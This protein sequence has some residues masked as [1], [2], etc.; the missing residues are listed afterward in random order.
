MNR[1]TLLTFML[2][3]VFVAEPALCQESS[4]DAPVYKALAC[5]RPT[6]QSTWAILERDG[7]SRQV[8]R[9]LSSL[10]QG[11]GGIGVISSPPFSIAGDTITFTI[12]GHDGQGGGRNENYIAL[13]DARKGTVLHKT[14][15]PG[16][17][18]LQESSWDVRDIKGVEVR[19]E[20]HDGNR[21]GAFAWLGIGRIDASPSLQ[22]DFSQ[23]MPAGWNRSQQESAVRYELITDGI[24]FRRDASIYSIIPEQGDVE[25]PCGFP[26]RRIYLL[27]CT[28]SVGRPLAVYG[29]LELHYQ[30]GSVD[31]MPLMYGFTLDGQDKLLSPSPTIHLHPSG[32]PFQYYLPIELRD[33]PLDKI[34]LV[35]NP[36]RGPIPR[37]TA[38]T[39]ETMAHSDH[40]SALPETKLA[41]EEQSWIRTHTVSAASPSRDEIASDIRAA[42]RLEKPPTSKVHFQ[43]VTIDTAFRSEGVAVADFNGDG[44]LDIATGNQYY[45][46]PDWKLQPMF[47][48]PVAFPLVGY[49]DSF[50]CF[51][52]DVNG[53]GAVDL[54]VVGFPGQTTHW[55]ANP[56]KSGGTWKK[57]LAVE[58]TGNESPD[59]VDVDGDGHRELLFINGSQCSVARPGEDPTA[60]WIV[61]P[62]AGPDD[63]VAGHGLGAGDV[64]GDGRVDIVIPDGWWEG[65]ATSTQTPWK[66]HKVPF[67]GGTQMCVSDLDGDGDNDVLGSSAHG[68]GI[69]WTEQTAEGWQIHEIDNTD[70]Q[71]HA[72]HLADVNRDGLI[73]FVTGK[74]F[75]AHNGHDPGS[76]EPAVLCWYEMR[77][78]DDQTTWIKHQID[79][80]SGVGLHFQIVD[81][82]GDGLLD[83]VTSN[84]KGVYLFQQLPQ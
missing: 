70:S 44:Q 49:S 83:I 12:R 25:I 65:P 81:M 36:S 42:Y 19:M 74:R 1:N 63:P 34:R 18:A 79:G 61:S 5:P 8:A 38:I 53:D 66:F 30:S 59:F 39:V 26:A 73:D 72:I 23:G 7:A 10:G 60:R 2:T 20:V 41:P 82:N 69:A 76:Y 68:Y 27:G 22:V 47:E 11:E 58:K 57:H 80:D 56:G 9:Y 37:I 67:F 33:E 55:L 32:D 15:A 21:A 45:T 14:N 17:D 48:R 46:G 28:V 62:I 64:N 77:R 4:S 75:W 35:S 13:V 78:Q 3:S 51:D 40:L 29:G 16:N 52:D 50:L 43:K 84:K 6:L 71:T 31:V 54:I 24:P